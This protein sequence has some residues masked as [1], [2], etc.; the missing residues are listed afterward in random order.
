VTIQDFP[1]CH[2]HEEAWGHERVLRMARLQEQIYAR[3]DT[4]DATSLP[5]LEELER[6]TGKRGLQ[7]LHQ[8]LE[9]EDFAY[10]KSVVSSSSRLVG[11]TEPVSASNEEPR[12]K[13]Y[14]PIKIAY[15][16]TILCQ[17]EFA[18]FV[19]ILKQLREPNQEPGTKNY[20]LHFYGAHSYREAPWFDATWM[21][22]HGNLSERDLLK[23]LRTCDWGFIP[24]SLDDEDPRYNRFSFPTKFITYL[25]AGLPII[26]MG[27][28]ESSVM[29]MASQGK[30]GVVAEKA[31][32]LAD[33]LATAFSNHRGER[34]LTSNIYACAD[35]FFHANRIRKVLHACLAGKLPEP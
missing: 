30:T 6:R 2:G 1:D 3:A 26:A 29:K 9:P 20:E 8:G 10:L 19:E 4:A 25:A 27:H 13:N 16:G 21:Q 17:R 24:M 15:A 14:E 34:L 5:M 32:T 12:T 28:P 22:E 35:K 33:I 7:M 11:Q 18:L 23:A 31:D